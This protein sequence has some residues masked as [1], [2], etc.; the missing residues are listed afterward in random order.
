MGK[1]RVIRVQLSVTIC[2]SQQIFFFRLMILHAA[3]GC[4]FMTTKQ[5]YTKPFACGLVQDCACQHAMLK[6]D[7]RY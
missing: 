7:E 3:F 6:H 4:I 5:L 1:K 2:T